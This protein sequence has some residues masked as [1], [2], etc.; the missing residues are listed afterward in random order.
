M[1]LAVEAV[2]LVLFVSLALFTRGAPDAI[3]VQ[4]LAAVQGWDAPW[5][6]SAMAAVTHLG[7][8]PV[9]FPA[10]MITAALL[11][12]RRK[13]RAALVVVL[14]SLTDLI[15]DGAV[16]AVLQ[17]D[18]P[19]AGLSLSSWSF[20]SGHAL[21]ATAVWGIMVAGLTRAFALPRPAR[22]ALWTAHVLLA[23]SVGLSRVA[24]GVHWPTDVV[25]GF[26]E[27]AM[28]L[29]I[30]ATALWRWADGRPT[31]RTPVP[32]RPIVQ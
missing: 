28:L 4:I 10:V 22:A 27:G 3:D 24:L 11:V 16:K 13:P 12:A 30:G 29:L 8:A 15:L 31:G 18:R 2:L 5:F 19:F 17:R 26:I 21:S 20:P 14:I 1:I 25:A 7:D 32:E 9:L 23:L 6:H